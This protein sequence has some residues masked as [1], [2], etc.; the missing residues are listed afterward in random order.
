M[1]G[2][3]QQRLSAYAPRLLSAAV[4]LTTLALLSLQGVDLYTRLNVQPL[5]QAHTR[6]DDSA[7]QTEPLIAELFGQAQFS[8][9][10]T[11]STPDLPLTLLG[12]VAHSDP[13]RS[14]ALIQ[15]QGQATRRYR[16][17]EELAPGISLQAVYPRYVELR[18]QGRLEILALSKATERPAAL[19]QEPPLAQT[20]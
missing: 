16:V 3:L 14:S 10:T 7:R 12:S 13:Q 1:R 19:A 18:Y 5:A 8:M 6:P 9:P 4:A 17:G 2:H 15:R 20:N 11:S